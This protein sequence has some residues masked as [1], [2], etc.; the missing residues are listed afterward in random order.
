ML[1]IIGLIGISLQGGF[2]GLYSLA[3]K[4]YPMEV[5]STG[6]GFAIGIGRMGAVI[7]PAIAGV[8]IAGG[9]T[10]QLN[11][12]IFAVPM[13]IGAIFAYILHVR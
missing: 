8:L 7:G 3:A 6:V 10:M 11:F 5:R 12:V 4:I 13:M 9:I 1:L 2:T